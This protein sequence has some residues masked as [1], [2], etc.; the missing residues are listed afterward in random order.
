MAMT[1]NR[2]I[3]TWQIAAKDLRIEIITPFILKIE[4]GAQIKAEILLKNFGATNGMIITKDYD[5]IA[6]F[7]DEIVS[8]GY[9]FSVLDEP[10]ENE[11]YVREDFV[12]IL[13]DWGWSGEK[14]KKPSWLR[15]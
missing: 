11:Q 6:P 5:Q 2:L 10:S 14:S 4:S 3:K 7:V 1:T 9:G 8:E 15:R 12:D 13:H